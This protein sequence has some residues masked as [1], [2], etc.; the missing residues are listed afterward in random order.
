GSFTIT[1]LP[2][3]RYRL[4]FGSPSDAYATT[5][6]TSAVPDAGTLDV[7]TVTVRRPYGWGTSR[8]VVRLSGAVREEPPTVLYLKDSRGKIVA[9]RD[10]IDFEDDVQE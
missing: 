1:G 6:T 3:G 4:T 2:A 5:V 7:G 8:L 9:Q 10:F